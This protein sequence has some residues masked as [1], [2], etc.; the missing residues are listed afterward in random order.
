[1]D[2]KAYPT[3]SDI[4]MVQGQLLAVDWDLQ[5]PTV[6]GILDT[7]KPATDTCQKNQDLKNAV[8]EL[9]FS[10]SKD[11]RLRVEELLD[12]FYE[13]YDIMGCGLEKDRMV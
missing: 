4:Y 9:R 12:T 11:K 10:T 2:L 7:E 13:L 5:C 8:E 6:N 1:M 3:Q